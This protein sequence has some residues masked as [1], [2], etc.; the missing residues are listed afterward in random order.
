MT[1]SPSAGISSLLAVQRLD[2]MIRLLGWIRE[3]LHRL[4]PADLRLLLHAVGHV[5]RHLLHATVLKPVI[6]T[7]VT[8]RTI[9][10]FL[11]CHIDLYCCCYYYPHHHHHTS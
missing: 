4:H 7:S 10:V 2:G 11:D 1:V 5:F 3:A 6:L 9:H 8:R